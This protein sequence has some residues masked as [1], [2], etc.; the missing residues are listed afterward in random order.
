MAGRRMFIALIGGGA[1]AAAA[2]GAL[3]AG[4]RDPSRARLPWLAAGGPSAD[5]RRIALSYAVL[6]PNPHNRQPW[7]A[8]LSVPGELTLYCDLD[9]RLPATD[10]FDRQITIGL[11]CFLELL[12]QAAAEAGYVAEPDLFPQGEPIPRLDG[13]PVA[14]VRFRRD[15]AVRRDPLF[16]HVLARRSN[17]GAFDTSRP[18]ADDALSGIA[19]AA[20]SSRAAH[21]NE[22]GQVERLRDMTWSAL[23]R[24]VTTP[25]A[26]GESIGLMR[27]GRAEIEAAPDGIALAGPRIEALAH[28]GLLSREAL[29]DPRSAAFRHQLEHLRLPTGTAMAFMWLVTAGNGRAA[30]IEAGRDHVR[31]NL[32]ATAIGVAMHPLSQALQEFPE[33]AAHRAAMRSLLGVGE[34]E[35]LQ[36]LVRLGYGPAPAPAPRW[37][38]QTRIGR[39]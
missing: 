17:K 33:M 36:M 6:A 8:D 38:W 14:R 9:R 35:T 4:T 16:P 18:V 24:E 5:V 37:A 32:A 27:I 31:I 15:D 26:L 19:G 29:A 30:Q 3:W 21:T 39:A 22:T 1:V 20:R 23:H 13:R 2:G 10:P 7:L 25:A 11:G 12:V 28:A 34:D